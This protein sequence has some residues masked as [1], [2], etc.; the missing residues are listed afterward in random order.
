MIVRVEQQCHGYK[1]GHQMLAGSLRLSRGDQDVVDRISDISGPLRPGE[2]FEPYL[3]AY[4]LPSSQFYVVARTWQDRNAPRAGCVLTRSLLI[5]LDDWGDLDYPSSLLSLLTPVDKLAPSVRSIDL[6]TRFVPS[7]PVKTSRVIPLVEALFLEERN[8]IAMFDEPEADLISI[9][10]LSAL[11]PARRKS[12]SLCTLSLSPRSISGRSFDL[13]FAPKETKSRYA[14][15]SGR[16]LNPTSNVAKPDAP[17]HR[18]SSVTTEHIFLNDPPSLMSLDAL[19]VLGAS[20]DGSEAGLRLALLW[21]E[22]LE[23]AETSPMAILG[24]LDILRSRGKFSTRDFMPFLPVLLRGIELAKANLGVSDLL[25][26]VL[27][28]VGKFPSKRPPID[29]LNKIREILS[30]SISLQPRAILELFGDERISKE[31]QSPVVTAGLGDGLARGLSGR[32]V[33]SVGSQFRPEDQMRLMSFSKAW[34]KSLM[35]AAAESS[36]SEWD[37]WLPRSLEYQDSHL[38]AKARRHATLFLKHQAQTPLLRA[39]LH[40]VDGETVLDVAKQIRLGTDYLVASFDQ[41]LSE[42]A[43]RT[44]VVLGLRAE[45]LKGRNEELADRFMSTTLSF[46]ARDID[47]LLDEESF[48]DIRR[49]QLIVGKM[50]DERDASVQKLLGEQR[51]SSRLEKLFFQRLPSSSVDLARVL[52]LGNL[53]LSVLL[54][55]GGRV[56]PSLD[57]PIKDDLARRMLERGLADGTDRDDPLLESLVSQSTSFSDPRTVVEMALGENVNKDRIVKNLSMLEHAKANVRRGFLN[58]IEVITDRLI[59]R[60]RLEWTHQSISVWMSLLNDAQ[61]VNP[62][63]QGRAAAKI[64]SFALENLDNPYSELVVVSFPLVYEQLRKGQ[65]SP[66]LL[67]LIFT[68]WDR[69]KTAR[70]DVMQAFLH[71]DWPAV[72]L[73]RA[74]A[75]T[76][77]FDKVFRALTRERDGDAFLSRLDAGISKLNKTHR[78]KVEDVLSEVL[79]A[80]SGAPSNH[81]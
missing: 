17:R 37:S 3:S 59:Y 57:A 39:M 23:K 45:I 63:G 62:Y 81:E 67:S 24:L 2:T 11:W 51:L 68:D 49:F 26:F 44:G 25:H 43:K 74:L 16:V 27:T 64:L 22:L 52:L 75:P 60:E 76:G 78:R 41:P 19:G 50:R 80:R 58:E 69:C 13:M 10:L 77:D 47:W 31:L 66:G 55:D 72:D 35:S 20:G 40:D 56:L 36:M 54:N 65:E 6:S 70:R 30:Y 32:E 38:R 61:T 28:L 34:T 21:N 9:R 73:V 14:H 29:V 18:W 7:D 71:S 5:R 15:W 33:L 46:D 42:A 1:N 53:P 48:T 8:P 79:K 12:F 4:P